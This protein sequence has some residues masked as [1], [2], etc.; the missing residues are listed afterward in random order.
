MFQTT[1][2]THPSDD[3]D[4]AKHFKAI[5]LG[6]VDSCR[7]IDRFEGLPGTETS[8]T[9]LGTTFG[10]ADAPLANGIVTVTTN[11]A[12]GDGKLF[13]ENG[14]GDRKGFETFT[15]DR[16]VDVG[17][18]GVD[19]DT[20]SGELT[21]GG[22]WTTDGRPSRRHVTAAATVTTTT[23]AA[24]ASR[25]GTNARRPP[26]VTSNGAATGSASRSSCQASSVSAID[27]AS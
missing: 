10:S 18:G 24:T 23:T 13:G 26:V 8:F 15:T 14:I 5:Y 25:T 21:A 16:A 12:N 1:T 11:D 19:V 22:D 17:G 4:A 6:D 3:A 20:L 9:L 27:A 7:Y 2:P